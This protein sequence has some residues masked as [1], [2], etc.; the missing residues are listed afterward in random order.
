MG[1]QIGFEFPFAWSGREATVY[2]R[3]R[4]ESRTLSGE[5]AM[6]DLD[7]I[8]D[9]IPPG[10]GKV[11]HLLRRLMQAGEPITISVNGRAQLPIGDSSYEELLT[12]VDLVESTELLRERLDAFH[13][14]EKG[15]SMEEIK[16]EA[17]RRYGPSH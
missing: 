13:A 6:L 17:R 16:E 5:V 14:G 2:D 7:R 9:Q 11:G 10:M 1:L 15:V 8:P 4:N 12:F 3:T